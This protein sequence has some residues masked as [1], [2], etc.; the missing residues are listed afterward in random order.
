MC[1]RGQ[2]SGG[3]ARAG[4]RAGTSLR[5][6][7]GRELRWGPSAS[8]RGR[9]GPAPPAPGR[10]APRPPARPPD[11]GPR[12]PPAAAPPPGPS[13]VP[14]PGFQAEFGEA[15]WAKGASKDASRIL[16]W[17]RRSPHS[18]GNGELGIRDQ[19]VYAAAAAAAAKKKK[20]EKVCF[21]GRERR[22]ELQGPPELGR[23]EVPGSRRFTCCPALPCLVIVHFS[24]CK[25]SAGWSV[26]HFSSFQTPSGE[27]WQGEEIACVRGGKMCS[28]LGSGVL[29]LVLLGALGGLNLGKELR[30]LCFW[31]VSSLLGAHSA[32]LARSPVLRHVILMRTLVVACLVV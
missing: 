15:V 9:L 13:F 28:V 30:V 4:A 32:D 16:K 24:A 31:T 2:V 17:E 14:H 23:A 8:G 27:V 12:L 29:C 18:P 26:T 6:G 25:L 22:E 5:G 20:T 1:A 19:S 11:V 7:S 3:R 10:A 21:V